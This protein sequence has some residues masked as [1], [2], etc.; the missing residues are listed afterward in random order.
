MANVVDTV[1]GGGDALPYSA[2]GGF[3]SDAA[4]VDG[5]GDFDRGEVKLV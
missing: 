4:E 1:L 5:G 2:Q 3:G